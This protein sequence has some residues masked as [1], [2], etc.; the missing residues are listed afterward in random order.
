MERG[1]PSWSME[2][3]GS[4]EMTVLAEKSTRLPMRLPLTLPS[5]P[6][7]PDKMSHAPCCWLPHS[8]A[9]IP[10]GRQQPCDSSHTYLLQVKICSSLHQSL[11]ASALPHRTLLKQINLALGAAQT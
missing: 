7:Q 11:A 4:P 3:L 1:T 2:M 5:L 9:C 6:W 8:P 10:M